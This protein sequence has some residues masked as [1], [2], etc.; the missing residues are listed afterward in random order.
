MLSFFFFLFCSGSLA[1]VDTCTGPPEPVLPFRER[2]LCFGEELTFS[3]DDPG[4]DIFSWEDGPGGTSRV[5]TEPGTYTLRISNACGSTRFN[6]LINHCDQD[7]FLPSGFSPN[8]DGVNDVFRLRS[9]PVQEFLLEVFNRKGQRLFSTTDMGSGW[10]G[11]SE[12]KEQP[13]GVYVWHLK[14]RLTSGREVQ[15][16][17]DITLV[18]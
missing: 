12:G 16:T 15:K 11:T 9:P 10:D 1:Q 6:I 4:Q 3:V 8:G 2:T 14:V 7:P 17:G 13:S 5:F 18:R